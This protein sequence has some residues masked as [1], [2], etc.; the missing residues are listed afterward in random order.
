MACGRGG[1]G[2]RAALRSLWP[3]G[4]GSSSLLDRTNSRGTQGR[5]VGVPAKPDRLAAV[6]CA[7]ATAQIRRE[8]GLRWRRRSVV[9]R[10]GRW[11]RVQIGDRR[12]SVPRHALVASLGQTGGSSV[13]TDRANDL[14]GAGTALR[15]SAAGGRRKADRRPEDA[16]P[17]FAK[18][19]LIDLR[20]REAEKILNR[21]VRVGAL[22]HPECPPRPALQP[23]ASAPEQLAAPSATRFQRQFACS[24]RRA[25]PNHAFAV[26]PDLCPPAGGQVECTDGGP[27]DR[28]EPRGHRLFRQ[29][30]RQ[31]ADGDPLRPV[32]A[33]RQD[34]HRGK[35]IESGRAHRLNRSTER[36]FFH[37]RKKSGGKSLSPVAGA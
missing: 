28:L 32:C 23:G 7:C 30:G 37:R 18:L 35:R 34:Q 31:R 12:R 33:G 15:G 36:W 1:T 21:A 13:V 16:A 10:S 25:D 14:P 4:R 5:P 6:L 29:S 11:Q 3:K 26:R 2:R 20:E 9:G 22:V 8:G 24:V 17:A 19:L 27:S